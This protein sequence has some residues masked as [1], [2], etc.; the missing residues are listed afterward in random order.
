MNRVKR[1]AH[2]K[3]GV[4]LRFNFEEELSHPR[5]RLGWFR[6]LVADLYADWTDRIISEDC[7]KLGIEKSTAVAAKRM[8][9]HVPRLLRG[10]EA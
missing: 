2:E 1:A 8:T 5:D 10:G 9:R 3:F 4:H 6:V 7:I